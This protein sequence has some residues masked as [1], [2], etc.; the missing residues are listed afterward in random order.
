MNETPEV[1]MLGLCQAHGV[2]KANKNASVFHYY[3]K[4][5]LKNGREVQNPNEFV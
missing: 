5:T 4:Y 2:L 3:Q 1:T